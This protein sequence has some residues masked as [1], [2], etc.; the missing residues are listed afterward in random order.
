METVD[1]DDDESISLR[2]HQEIVDGLQATIDQWYERYSNLTERY[3]QLRDSIPAVLANTRA[4]ETA[5]KVAMAQ[6]QE[7]VFEMEEA[8]RAR[9][10]D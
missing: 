10:T 1:G 8:M 5:L 9:F 4:I 6:V 3:G 2:T 7:R